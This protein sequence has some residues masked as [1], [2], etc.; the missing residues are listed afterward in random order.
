MTGGMHATL[1]NDYPITVLQ[2]HSV[3]EMVLSADPVDYTG[4]DRPS[5]VVALANEG[6]G[7]RK[8]LLAKLGKDTLILKVAGVELPETGASVKEIDFKAQKIKSQDWALA[9]LALV[10][11]DER[12]I[13]LEM[14]KAALELRFNKTVFELALSVVEKVTA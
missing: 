2:G 8:K 9:S 7:R 3:S 4:I 1:K 13:S 5:V 11:K 10:A 12:I 6:V 14:L